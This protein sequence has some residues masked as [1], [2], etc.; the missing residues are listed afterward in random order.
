[1]ANESIP[2]SPAPALPPVEPGGA[3]A[4]DPADQQIARRQKMILAAVIAGA[5]L[6]I[7]VLITVFVILLQ[8]SVPTETIRDVF[9]IFLA[10]ESLLVGIAVIILMIQVATL[11]NLL[12]NEIRPMLDATN[13]TINTLRGTTEFMSENLVEPVIQLNEYLA[14]LQRV[15]ELMGIKKK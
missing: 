6:F 10:L 13:E 15:L 8:P 12:Q 14:S 9:T 4:L 11:V 5:V 1:M 7:F 2:T 3:P